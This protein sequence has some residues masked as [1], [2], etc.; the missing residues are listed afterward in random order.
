MKKLSLALCAWAFSCAAA[1]AQD[2]T[3]G[4]RLGAEF[5]IGSQVELNL[6]GQR[7]LNRYLSWDVLAVKYAHELGDSDRLLIYVRAIRKIRIQQIRVKPE[8]AVSKVTDT[9]SCFSI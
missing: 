1:Q 5:G 9:A 7:Q 8:E 4:M 3:K 6:R 2:I